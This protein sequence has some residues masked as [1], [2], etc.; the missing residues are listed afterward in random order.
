MNY[1]LT[2][3]LNGLSFS[4]ILYL[5]AI[6][7]TLIMGVMRVVNLMHGSGYLLGAYVALT[8]INKTDSFLLGIAA[9]ILVGVAVACLIF[10]LLQRVGTDLNRQAVLTFAFVFII[11]DVSLKL[12]GGGTLQIPIPSFL[13][14]SVHLLGISYPVYR[15]AMIGIVAIVAF[16]LFMIE[17]KTLWGAL[18]RAVADNRQ[19]AAGLGRNPMFIALGTFILGIVLAFM[20]GVLGAGVFGAFPGA[21]IQFLVLGL[22]IV[23][24][25]GMGS[26]N[27]SLLAAVAVG[28]VSTLTKAI[29][30][31]IGDMS[32]FVL[33]I[34]V[35]AFRPHGLLGR[36]A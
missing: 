3:L 31:S 4:A 12:F 25:G 2:Q 11:A 16:A 1:W 35:L 21:D 36:V 18:V 9:A 6:G 10:A 13:Q 24:L 7:L 23:V 26:I 29:G 27:G 33:L 14:G 34:T 32:I 5:I 28:L 22:V 15:L 19:M 20:G 30:P 8:V 17:R